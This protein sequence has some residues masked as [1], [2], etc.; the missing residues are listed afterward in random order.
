MTRGVEKTPRVFCGVDLQSS[1]KRQPPVDRMWSIC[2]GL[3]GRAAPGRPES[4]RGGWGGHS[5][6]RIRPQPTVKRQVIPWCL[7]VQSAFSQALMD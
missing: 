2:L 6:G 1:F 7:A 3:T 5:S 4:C